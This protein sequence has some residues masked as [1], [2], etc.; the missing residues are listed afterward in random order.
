M[1]SNSVTPQ[2]ALFCGVMEAARLLCVS[3]STTY[4]L[5]DDGSLKS[6]KLGKRRLI[7]IAS[8]NSFAASLPIVAS[9]QARSNQAINA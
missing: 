4:E 9:K 3:R 5:L 6:V 2:A 8:I 7:E 1:T